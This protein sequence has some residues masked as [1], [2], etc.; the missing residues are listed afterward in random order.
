MFQGL[1]QSLKANFRRRSAFCFLSSCHPHST[2][3]VVR[4]TFGWAGKYL[5]AR[6]LTI[7]SFSGHAAIWPICNDLGTVRGEARD[8]L[9]DLHRSEALVARM[10]ESP[11]I[12]SGCCEGIR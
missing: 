3:R 12:P 5:N 10:V 8:F 9:G 4:A 1:M 11:E 2:E 7:P 6:R